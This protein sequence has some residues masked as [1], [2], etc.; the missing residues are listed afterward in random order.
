[1]HQGIVETSHSEGNDIRNGENCSHERADPPRN[2][3]AI[4][5]PAPWK[6]EVEEEASAE[7]EGDVYACFLF[8]GNLREEVILTYPKTC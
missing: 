4:I 8:S 5:F 1:M 6:H 3:Y 7:D 2:S